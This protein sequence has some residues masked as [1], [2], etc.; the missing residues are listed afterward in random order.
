MFS[1]NCNC[2]VL[3]SITDTDCMDD[4][5]SALLLCGTDQMDIA[6]KTQDR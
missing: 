2:T 5:H 3:T 6:A 1:L 4:S